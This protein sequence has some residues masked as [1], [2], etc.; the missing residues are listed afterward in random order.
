MYDAK[1]AEILELGEPIWVSGRI[2]SF[3]GHVLE[4]NE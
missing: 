3:N 2:T 1:T 4:K